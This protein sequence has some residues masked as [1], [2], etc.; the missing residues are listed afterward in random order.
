MEYI[1]DTLQN[2]PPLPFFFSEPYWNKSVSH[3]GS[4]LEVSS[5]AYTNIA[6]LLFLHW[7]FTELFNIDYVTDT[8]QNPPPLTFFFILLLNKKCQSRRVPARS[9]KPCLL[10]TANNH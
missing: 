7:Y 2:P 1:T 9:V 10:K 4:R 5:H 6:Y 3:A 8:L